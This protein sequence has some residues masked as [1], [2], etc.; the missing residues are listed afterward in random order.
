MLT[1]VFQEKQRRDSAQDPSD[2]W[3]GQEVIAKDGRAYPVGG[4]YAVE[5]GIVIRHWE[6]RGQAYIKLRDLGK[7]RVPL[8]GFFNASKF[9]LAK[10]AVQQV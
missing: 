5:G 6:D 9:K 10:K 8:P 4:N 2:E 3:T 7:D 1:T